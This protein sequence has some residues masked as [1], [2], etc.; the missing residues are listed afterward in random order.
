MDSEH[1]V[2]LGGDYEDSRVNGWIEDV[3]KKTSVSVSQVCP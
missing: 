3:I 2:A 1:L